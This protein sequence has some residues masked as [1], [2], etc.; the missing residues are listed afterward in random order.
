MDMWVHFQFTDNITGRQE[1]ACQYLD[2]NG[3]CVSQSPVPHPCAKLNVQQNQKVCW[4]SSR[5]VRMKKF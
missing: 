5:N 3:S 1:T 4:G 2:L